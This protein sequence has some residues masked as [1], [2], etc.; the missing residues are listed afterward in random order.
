MVTDREANDGDTRFVSVRNRVWSTILI[1]AGLIMA[2]VAS[3]TISVPAAL[4]VEAAIALECLVLGVR[5]F[6][7]SSITISSRNVAYRTRRLTKKSI[8]TA[9][10]A[11]VDEASRTLLYNRVFPRIEMK[12]GTRVDLIVFEQSKARRHQGEGSVATIISRIDEALRLRPES[13]I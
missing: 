6:V 9:D 1:A 11:S 7:T 4:I 5:L 8:S 2:A 13:G 3:L 10:I 12:S